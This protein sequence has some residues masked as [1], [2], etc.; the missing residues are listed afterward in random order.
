MKRLNRRGFT[1]IEAIASFVIVSIVLTT[2]AIL[3]VN[4]YN[5]S[6]ATSR[7]VDAVHVGSLIRDDIA[8]DATYAT[9]LLWL[10]GAAATLTA[11]NCDDLGSPF[12]CTLFAYEADGIVYDA[13]VVVSFEAPTVESLLYKVI[14][15][16]VTVTYYGAR[17]VII[18]GMIYDV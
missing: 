16:T 14:R 11:D 5:Q 2:A 3:I 4:S 15:F 17:T 8:A 1:L 13:E 7:Q 9:V 10:D 18:E 12:A 6:V